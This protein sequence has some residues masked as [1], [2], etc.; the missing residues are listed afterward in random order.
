MPTFEQ[1]P[2]LPRA[3]ESL[4]AQTLPEWELVVVDDGSEDETSAVLEAYLADDRIAYHALERNEGLGA[5]L[6]RALALTSAPLVA[7][8]PSDDLYFPDHLASLVAL[9]E[10]T[11][12]VAAYAGVRHHG[13]RESEGAP[14]GF[15]L[16]L[17]QVLHR[18]TG[19]RWLERDELVTDDLERMFW[20][21]LRARGRFAGTGR[22][23]CAWVDHP[24]QR[25]K[26]LREPQGGVNPYRSRYRVARPI[27]LETSTGN[28]IDEVGLYRRFRERPAGPRPTE[29]G[30]T[31]LLVGELAYNPERVLALEERGHRLLGLW[32]TDLEW[33][34]AVGPLPFGHV[35]DLPRRGWREAVRRLQ[36]DLVYALLNWRAVPLAHEVL[37][38][39]LGIPFVWHFKESPFVCI[40]RGLWKELFDL[41][42]LAD[43]RV[44]SSPEA[45][46]WFS[47]VLPRRD[48]PTLLLDGDL[49]KQEW[50]EGERAPLLSAD[51]GEPHTVVPGRPVGLGPDR[52]RELAARGVHLH[53]YGNFATWPD[54][55]WLAEVRA[56]VSRYLHFHPYIDQRSWVTE[57]S[58]YDAG[59]LHFFASRNGGEIRRASWHDLNYPARIPVLAAGGLPL[60]QRAN[61]GSIV[62]TEALARELDIGLSF[63]TI[64]EL[65]SGLRDGTRMAELR[66][67][68]W[69]E[70]GRF[71]FDH[72][73]DR[74]V[75]FFRHVIEG[76]QG[77]GGASAR[78]GRSRPLQTPRR[79]S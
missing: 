47:T 37:T 17:V 14:D 8:L 15:S 66:D 22:V 50:F 39:R 31:I 71:T 18:R 32:I 25:H 27:R 34:N 24:D 21:R 53:L 58:R 28:P 63:E 44:Y 72:H 30:L 13:E 41:Y 38:A 26:V 65:A 35:E 54:F 48:T 57:L 6:N 2:F 43:G 68:V 49:P 75:A 4:L 10:G 45:R 33:F 19:D 11:E 46:E 36:P 55:E 76:G 5:A 70:R 20:G 7:Y 42:A 29:D 1:A 69:R 60:L 73:A 40:A 62:A 61:P 3:L 79:P 64:D 51:D 67:R 56:E 23:T 59:W 77:N 78:G 12:A 16:Q 52:V 74:L 9:L